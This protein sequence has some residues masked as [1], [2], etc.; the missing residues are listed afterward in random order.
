M[1]FAIGIRSRSFLRVCVAKIED[2]ELKTIK[3]LKT[4]AKLPWFPDIIEP[5]SVSEDRMRDLEFI[6]DYVENSDKNFIS[7]PYLSY[8]YL[9]FLKTHLHLRVNICIMII[10]C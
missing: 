9:I 4:N 8:C 1:V 6:R 3:I 2:G 5:N 10:S 7:K